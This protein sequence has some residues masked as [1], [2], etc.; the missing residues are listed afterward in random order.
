MDSILKSAPLAEQPSGR[1]VSGLQTQTQ[2]TN[3]VL[4][5][6]NQRVLDNWDALPGDTRVETK[7][8]AL[9]CGIGVSTL[10]LYCRRGEFPKGIKR[11]FKTT[12]SK[13]QVLDW[14]A[15]RYAEAV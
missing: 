10:W 1:F 6:A 3:T 11:G 2:Y 15:K 9:L 5:P 12:W 14:K 8:V 4:S 7:L 13:Q